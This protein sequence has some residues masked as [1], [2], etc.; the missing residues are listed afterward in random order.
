MVP[1]NGA[2]NRENDDTRPLP[3]LPPAM[4]PVKA[5]AWVNAIPVTHGQATTTCSPSL[6]RIV[7]ENR[8]KTPPSHLQDRI[9]KTK[10]RNNRR[11]QPSLTIM[12]LPA[13]LCTIIATDATM[14]PPACS[15]E[16]RRRPR[17]HGTKTKAGTME[18]GRGPDDRSRRSSC[19]GVRPKHHDE[20]APQ[21]QHLRQATATPAAPGKRAADHQRRRSPMDPDL[22]CADLAP[23]RADPVNPWPNRSSA[24][25]RTH[26]EGR[27]RRGKYGG[28]ARETRET[29]RRRL[30][31]CPLRSSPGFW[32]GAP[33]AAEVTSGGVV[34]FGGGAGEPPESP[35]WTTRGRFTPHMMRG[36][37]D[38]RHRAQRTGSTI[39]LRRPALPL[40][41]LGTGT[42]THPRS[43]SIPRSFAMTLP[44][45]DFD[46]DRFPRRM[47]APSSKRSAFTFFPFTGRENLQQLELAGRYHGYNGKASPSNPRICHPGKAP[48]FHH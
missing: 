3:P 1:R 17:H 24:M 12:A 27:A 18:P 28:G 14:A 11:L 36:D 35:N 19:S 4:A 29:H 10:R 34:E 40:T 47:H 20:Q 33:A 43:S 31:R 38:S 9:A 22:Q 16:S 23:R 5:F 45:C 26:E 30:R 2:P 44:Q 8:R 39:R 46:I 48:K 21:L 13:H 15:R 42:V 7:A 37:R 25:S 32:R 41:I 6:S